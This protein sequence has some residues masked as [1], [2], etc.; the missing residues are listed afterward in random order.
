MVH[1]EKKKRE[2][3]L[4]SCII[5]GMQ[6]GSSSMSQFDKYLLKI[7]WEYWNFPI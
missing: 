4:L 3:W 2:K 6:I 1:F 7:I 5:W